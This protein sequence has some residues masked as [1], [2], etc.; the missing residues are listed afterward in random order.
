MCAI[1]P[2]PR[3]QFSV[4]ACKRQTRLINLLGIVFAGIETSTIGHAFIDLLTAVLSH[5][6]KAGAV[7]PGA[8]TNFINL[9]YTS[10]RHVI[11]WPFVNNAVWANI[12]SKLIS[13]LKFGNQVLHKIL[14]WSTWMK[15]YV[16]FHGWGFI[17]IK[18]GMKRLIQ[19]DICYQHLYTIYK[20]STWMETIFWF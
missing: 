14:K 2:T 12:G 3:W 1:D 18:Y 9:T 15:T 4:T 16:C 13:T 11:I 6:W 19:I 7:R 17:C 20:W 10:A 8:H 5:N